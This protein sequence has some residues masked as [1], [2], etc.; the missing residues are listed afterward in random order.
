VTCETRGVPERRRKFWGWGYEGDGLAPAESEALARRLADAFGADAVSA[1]RPPRVEDLTLRPARVEP[2][3]TLSRLF[4]SLPRERAAHAYGKSYRDLARAFRAEAPNPPDLVAL[5]ADEEDVAAV[6][7]WAG[8]EQVAVVPYGGGSSVVGG[9]EPDVGDDYRGAV[10]L[11]LRRL[12]RVLE[13]DGASRSALIEAGALGPRLE[14]QLEPHGLT[15][16]HYPQSFEFSSLGG[17]IATRAG[18]HYATL[19]THVDEFV[20]AV[21]LVT[22]SGV[23]ETRRLP[24]SGAGPAPERLFCGSEGT[25]GV[26]TRAWMRL[27]ERPRVRAAATVSFRDFATGAKAARSV[28]QS[29][30][31]PANCRLLDPLEALLAGSGDGSSALLLLAFESPGHDVAPWLAAA[32]DLCREQGGIVEGASGGGGGAGAWRRAF[33]RMPYVYEQL[34]AFGMLTGTFETAITWDRFEAFHDAVSDALRGRAVELCGGALVSSRLAY[35]YPDGAAPYYTL[36]AP[37]R[38]GAELEQWDAL[39][40]TASDAILAL[41]GTITHHHGVGREHRPWYERELPPLVL[42]ALR[43]AKLELDPQGILNPGVLL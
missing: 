42:D 19:H 23:V 21:R 6:L 2:P 16:R 38:A 26:I 43:A 14:A 29:G 34:V 31:H 28:A 18:G 33:L 11:D 17:W 10:S 13:V 5:P 1:R 22:P 12:D 41:G 25:L 39:K 32:L 3:A 9:V 4:T 20:Q 40:A 27:Q 35:V 30:L 8:D 36:V 7:A 37:A 24:A 15:L